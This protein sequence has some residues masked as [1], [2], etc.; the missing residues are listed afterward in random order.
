MHHGHV[1][2]AAQ[3]P[4]LAPHG[5]Q[6]SA[7]PVAFATAAEAARALLVATAAAAAAPVGDADLPKVGDA[8]GAQRDD[9]A[10][11]SPT[12]DANDSMGGGAADGIANKRGFSDVAAAAR[13]IAAKA[14]AKV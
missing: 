1:N 7:Q 6:Q 10:E 12:V 3:Q 8:G 5:G 13:D 2:A 14:K 4:R 11:P 9:G